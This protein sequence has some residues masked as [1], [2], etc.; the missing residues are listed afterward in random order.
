MTENNVDTIARVYSRLLA[1]KK[2]LPLGEVEDKYV[3]EYHSLLQR[4]EPG[5][6]VEEFKIPPDWVISTIGVIEKD[7]LTGKSKY[8]KIRQVQRHLFLTKV[9]GLL[10][11][12][13]L[14]G[15]ENSDETT[16]KFKGRARK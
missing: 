9:E 6:D 11:Y 2:N 1:L 16:V 14:L 7:Y 5:F 3:D 10:N 8:G 13:E 15:V 4:L 12:F